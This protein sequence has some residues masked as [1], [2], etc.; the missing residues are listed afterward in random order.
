VRE[1]ERERE[2]ERERKSERVREKE[3]ERESE[4]EKERKREREKERD[5]AGGDTS[6]SL[7]RCC[8]PLS[9]LLY[10]LSSRRRTFYLSFADI[11]P[12]GD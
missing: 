9:A 4:R 6:H 1:R 3:R 8:T 7:T 2:K 12:F 11:S 10:S 5:G